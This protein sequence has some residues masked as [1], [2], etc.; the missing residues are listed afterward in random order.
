MK[1]HLGRY[2][3]VVKFGLVGAANTV[4]TLALILLL[5]KILGL[6][7]LIVNPISYLLPTISSFYFNKK[8]TFRSNGKVKREGFF[9]FVVIGVAWLVQYCFLFLVVEAMKVDSFVAQIAGMIVFTSI[10]FLGQ[11]FITFKVK[12]NSH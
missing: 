7:Y 6:N 12:V 9:F 3:Q 10:N 8:W 4:F 11:K 1:K 2:K 5:E